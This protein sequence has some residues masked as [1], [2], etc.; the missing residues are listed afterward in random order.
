MKLHLGS[1]FTE[2]VYL[3]SNHKEQSD[4]SRMWDIL[5]N[6]WPGILKDNI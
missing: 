5:R 4:K 1:S 6:G 2:N 3:E